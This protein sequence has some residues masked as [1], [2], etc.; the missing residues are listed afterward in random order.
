MPAGSQF[1]KVVITAALVCLF[2]CIIFNDAKKEL[3][4][5]GK[6]ILGG[7]LAVNLVYAA[8]RSVAQKIKHVSKNLK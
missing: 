5:I 6:F 8:F 3:D 7:V 2:C 1:P 4:E